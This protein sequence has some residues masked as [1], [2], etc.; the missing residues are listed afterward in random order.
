MARAARRNGRILVPDALLDE[1]YAFLRIPSISS[2][3]GDPADL[4]RAARVGLRAHRGGRR[5]ARRSSPTA[6]NP[7]A[8]GELR[9][10]RADAPTVLIYG[11]YDVQCP[12]PAEEWHTPPFEPTMRDGRAV[13]ARRLG[14]QG[15]L[16]AAPAR[17]LPPGARGRAAGARA[18]ARRGRGGDRRPPR[19]STGSPRPTSA[20]PTARSSSTRGWRTRTRPRSRSACAASS[21]SRSTS[22]RRRATCTRGCTAAR[23]ERDA[24]AHA[25]PLPAPARR[26]WAAARRAACRPDRADRGRAGVLGQARRMAR[27]CSTRSV[28]RRSA[29]RRRR[30]STCATGRS[31]ASTSTASRPATRSTPARSC[32]ARRARSSRSASRRGRTPRRSATPRCA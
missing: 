13:R 26:G 12:T 25:G 14:R 16:P 30:T 28:R 15:Q 9:S 18:G 31:R 3:G 32:S 11:H 24:R 2:G 21:S 29:R 7:L 1:L 17:G 20:A 4:E 8:V 10:F 6:G 23:A 5:D 27:S 22:A 19:R